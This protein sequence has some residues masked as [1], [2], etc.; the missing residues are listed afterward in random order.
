M[1]VVTTD[2]HCHRPKGGGSAEPARMGGF[3]ISV[4]PTLSVGPG[5]RQL[6]GLGTTSTR[7]SL[8]LVSGWVVLLAQRSGTAG[9]C[10]RGEK[11]RWCVVGVVCG[12]CGCSRSCSRWLADH[13]MARRLSHCRSTRTGSPRTARTR[14]SKRAVCSELG[15]NELMSNTT[16][17]QKERLSPHAT[18]G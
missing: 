10:A 6:L 4:R 2:W 17:A 8:E 18:M 1:A 7:H 9:V 11:R 13:T 12:W 16:D 14:P 5:P 3:D 15:V